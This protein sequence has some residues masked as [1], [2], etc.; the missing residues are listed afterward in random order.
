MK[1]ASL[2]LFAFLFSALTI[3]GQDNENVQGSWSGFVRYVATTSGQLGTSEIT[4]SLAIKENKVTGSHIYDAT[5]ILHNHHHCEVVDK[6]LLKAVSVRA[7]NGTYDISIQGPECTGADADPNGAEIGIINQKLL[8]KNGKFEINELSGTKVRES[9]VGGDLGKTIYKTT[10]NLTRDLDV[11]L[12]VTP[13]GFDIEKHQ[14]SYDDWL[15][16]PGKDEISKGS[17]MKIELSLKSKSGKPLEYKAQSFGLRLSNTST[18]PGITINYPVEPQPNQLP[19]LRF[20]HLPVAE[21]DAQD[22]YITVSCNNG[23]TGEAFIASY[24]GGGATT[25]T[26]EATLVGGIS[27]S[28]QLSGSNDDS[29]QIPKRAAGTMIA[30]KWLTDNGNPKEMDD[31]DSSKGNTN[32]GDGFTAYEE[33]RGVI[34]QEKFKRLNPKKKEVGI[35][36]TQRDFRLFDGGIAWFKDASELEPVHFDFDKNEVTPRG[37][38]NFN[39]RSHHDFDQFAIYL[40]NGGLGKNTTL[41]VTYCNDPLWI[42]A[43]I[44]GVVIDANKIHRSYLKRISEALPETLK[45]SEQEYLIQTVA[46]ELGHA[47]NID[48]HGSDKPHVM[49]IIPSDRVFLRNGNLMTPLPDSLRNIGDSTGTAEAGNISCM[50]NYYPYF[51]WGHTIGAD[52]A[53]IYNQEPLLPLGRIFCTSPNGTGINSTKLYFGNAQIGDCLGHIQLRN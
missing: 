30:T 29:I 19:D 53:N 23:T 26:V 32:K 13:I 9:D 20:I 25:L 39:N 50:L 41:G 49:K 3:F 33:Y 4:I 38:I 24:D 27:I 51:S 21:S 47:V 10:W 35:L 17:Y 14:K 1:K 8:M 44:I 42:P 7:F 12:I 34:S 11:K 16:E 37:Q 6:G 5:D 15:P 2:I 52:G 45:F 46:H 48:H 43:N 40:F 36:A 31:L 22:Q 28:G 18:E